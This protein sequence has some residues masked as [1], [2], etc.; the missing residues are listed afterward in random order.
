MKIGIIT[1]HYIKNYGAFLQTYALQQY[2]TETYPDAEVVIVN[3]VKRKH[4]I[5]NIGG[6]FRFFW[7]KESIGAYLE[8]IKIPGTFSKAEKQYLNI[9]KKVRNAEEINALELDAIII[10]SDE[11][12]HYEDK[13]A[14]PIKFAVGLKADKI[15]SYA[16]SCGGVNLDHPI[17]NY[18]QEG[19]KKFTSLSARDDLSEQLVQR[20]LNI[21]PA[22]VLDPTLLY[23]F[24]VY[25][26]AFTRK[27]KQEKYLLMY[28]CERLPEEGHQKIRDYADA[29]G[30][31]IYG[32]GEY[33]KYYSEITINVSP[34]QW[35]EMFRN[36]QF[37]LTGTF[38]GAV[39]SLITQRNFA[40]YVTNPSRV[41]KV[42]S[43][44]GEFDLTDRIFEAGEIAR[45]EHLMDTSIDYSRFNERKEQVRQSSYAFLE[46]AL[47]GQDK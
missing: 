34:F 8:K 38:H 18:V 10:G 28:F 26:D 41:K 16:P 25:E 45:M 42:N 17:P 46:Q 20:V 15:I 37:V 14:S 7:K 4:Q 12:W 9:T 13:S 39:F 5:I 35:V 22:R 43:L 19:L 6:C 29:H 24:P 30:W 3:Y 21:T 33:A 27:I 32:A 23:D 36:A 31:K 1:H 2:L 40:A 44:L 11:V 47:F